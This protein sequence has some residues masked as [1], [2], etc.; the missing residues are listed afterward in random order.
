MVVYIR[1]VHAPT[2]SRPQEHWFKVTLNSVHQ[3]PDISTW[4]LK[5]LPRNMMESIETPSI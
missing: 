2:I 3:Y 4:I 5:E 1:A